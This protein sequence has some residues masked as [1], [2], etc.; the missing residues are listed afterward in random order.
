MK[1]IISRVKRGKDTGVLREASGQIMGEDYE[2]RLHCDGGG[3]PPTSTRMYTVQLFPKTKDEPE[4][5]RIFYTHI[6]ANYYF[7]KLIR[8]YGFLEMEEK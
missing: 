4:D 5:S 3:P 7:G 2:L 1:D 8:K 6:H